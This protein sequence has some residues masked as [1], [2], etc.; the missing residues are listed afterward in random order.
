MNEDLHTLL[1]EKELVQ[2]TRRFNGKELFNYH[3]RYNRET[4]KDEYT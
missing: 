1:V 4:E 3:S 2:G